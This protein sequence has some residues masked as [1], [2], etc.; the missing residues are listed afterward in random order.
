[1]GSSPTA[2]C[3]KTIWEEYFSYN[4]IM[5]IPKD[6]WKSFLTQ[7]CPQKYLQNSSCDISAARSNTK[8]SEEHSFSIRNNAEIQTLKFS[9]SLIKVNRQCGFNHSCECAF[10]NNYCCIRCRYKMH[11]IWNCHL[12]ARHFWVFASF[13]LLVTENCLF[14]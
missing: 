2:K 3:F 10:C 14:K 11:N 5:Y 13:I 7:L 12:E 8:A 4:S 6:N 9:S 1:M